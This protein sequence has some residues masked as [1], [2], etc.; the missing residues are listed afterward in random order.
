VDNSPKVTVR[1][2]HGHFGRCVDE[3]RSFLFSAFALTLQ[4]LCRELPPKPLA[5]RIFPRRFF[6]AGPPWNC[7]A[8]NEKRQWGKASPDFFEST[9]VPPFRSH[10]YSPP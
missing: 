5:A 1:V 4:P 2:P 6:V 8:L 3:L 10:E 7:W 9:F